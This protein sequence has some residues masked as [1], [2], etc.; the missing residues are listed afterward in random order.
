M[1]RT[2][3]SYM[4]SGCSFLCRSVSF[5]L[6]KFTCWR[7]KSATTFLGWRKRCCPDLPTHSSWASLVMWTFAQ[8]SLIFFTRKN[9]HVEGPAV[10][11]ARG[12]ELINDAAVGGRGQW[13][14]GLYSGDL[15]SP[16]SSI[17]LF[18]LSPFTSQEKVKGSGKV[19]E[20][21]LFPPKKI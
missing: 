11:F 6:D 7:A 21:K 13:C 4:A 19:S 17:S 12:S 16:N 20:Q 9:W 18:S 3:I 1:D 15:G 2:L 8:S 10:E 5:V 14:R